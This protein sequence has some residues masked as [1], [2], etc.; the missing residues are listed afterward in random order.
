MFLI[1]TKTYV[2]VLKTIDSMRLCVRTD[3]KCSHNREALIY[4]PRHEIC[5]NVVCATS[6][7]SNQRL[8]TRSLVRAFASRINIL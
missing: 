8:H 5:N 6:K 4:E 3:S 2:E 7:G 1:L